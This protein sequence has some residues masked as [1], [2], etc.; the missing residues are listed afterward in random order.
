MA[1]TLAATANDRV[2]FNQKGP[3]LVGRQYAR[4]RWMLFRAHSLRAYQ[5]KTGKPL[6]LTP[7]EIADWLNTIVSGYLAL[8]RGNSSDAEFRDHASEIAGKASELLTLLRGPVMDDSIPAGL[9]DAAY[10]ALFGQPLTDREAAVVLARFVERID[11]P[12]LRRPSIDQR[13]E[14]TYRKMLERGSPTKPASNNLKKAEPIPPQEIKGPGTVLAALPMPAVIESTTRGLWLLHD[15][16]REASERWDRLI[17]PKLNSAARNEHMRFLVL[18]LVDLYA[19]G[20]GGKRLRR[21]SARS[22]VVAFCQCTMKLIAKR[23]T[24]HGTPVKAVRGLADIE[25]KTIE[26]YCR[27]LRDGSNET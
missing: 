18:G 8:A 27:S 19:A 7:K 17:E 14:E 1:G 10:E 20:F 4:E 21:P 16:A 3:S 5:K 22:P 23:L 12:T 13:V 2:P 24:R 11:E 25:P 9:S 15:V 6:H 26:S